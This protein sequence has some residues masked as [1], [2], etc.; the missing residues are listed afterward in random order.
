MKAYWQYAS[1]E[2]LKKGQYVKY[3]KYES[4]GEKK[5]LEIT[6]TGSNEAQ[7]MLDPAP[8]FHPKQ[9]GETLT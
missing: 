2:V 6:L 4:F 5:G 7:C 1:G 3:Y 8:F 9:V